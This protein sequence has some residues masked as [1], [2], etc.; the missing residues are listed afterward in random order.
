M[1][2]SLC[3]R[4]RFF[5]IFIDTACIFY[6]N[7]IEVAYKEAVAW[8]R[9]DELIREEA[10]AGPVD[11]RQKSKRGAVEKEK[12]SKKKQVLIFITPFLMV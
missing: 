1:S 2:R 4:H 6:S 12:K 7:K 10:A 3:S 11:F 9:Q 8:K 5:L